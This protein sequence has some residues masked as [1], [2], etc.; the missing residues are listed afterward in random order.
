MLK[1]NAILVLILGLVLLC[2]N[3]TFGA[4][5]RDKSLPE[6]VIK[7]GAPAPNFTLQDLEGRSISLQSLRGKVVI[8]TFWATWCPACRTEL[9]SLD[10]LNRR[11][12]RRGAV[13][14]GI[15]GG[16]PIARVKSFMAKGNLD[17]PVV[18]DESGDIHDLYQ[19]RQYPTTFV[20]DRQGRLVDRHIGLRD[21]NAPEHFQAL[22]TLIGNAPEE[23]P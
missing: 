18:M 7:I 21:W 15:N 20:I 2:C 1:K 17:F 13:V 8:L 3:L 9:P 11:L 19:V 22:R 12:A 6:G 23:R 14:L 4:G 5:R 16:E 10:A